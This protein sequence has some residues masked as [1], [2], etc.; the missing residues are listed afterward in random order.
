MLPAGAHDANALH[1]EPVRSDEILRWVIGDVDRVLCLDSQLLQQ[2][3]EA[4]EQMVQ[5][6]AQI[7]G[8]KRFQSKSRGALPV[9]E[10]EGGK[11]KGAVA[12]SVIGQL[13]AEACGAAR[14]PG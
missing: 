7:T 4:L 6:Y 14:L 11:L 8:R 5:S 12:R 3:L 9:I 2:S 1:A 10:S 13:R